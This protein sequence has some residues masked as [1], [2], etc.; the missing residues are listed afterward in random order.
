MGP[1]PME[2]IVIAALALIVLGPAKLPEVARSVG[3]GLREMREA[4][5]GVGDEEDGDLSPLGAHGDED[6]EDDDYDSEEDADPDAELDSATEP[7]TA[8]ELDSASEPSF[9]G[10]RGG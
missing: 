3:R 10:D 2:W 7:E 8:V 9:K 4:L 5:Q 6:L 1:S